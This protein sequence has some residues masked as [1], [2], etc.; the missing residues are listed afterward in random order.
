LASVQPFVPRQGE[1][2]LGESWQAATRLSVSIDADGEV[3]LAR[4]APAFT[5][6]EVPQPVGGLLE[7]E[8]KAASGRGAPH[9][10][11]IADEVRGIEILLTI[12]ALPR[13][14]SLR[15]DFMAG[16]E[17]LVGDDLRL[18][19]WDEARQSCQLS[20]PGSQ[21]LSRNFTLPRGSWLVVV[22]RRTAARTET[23][24]VPLQ[25]EAGNGQ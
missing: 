9:T 18:E 21:F 24:E 6:H 11:T 22:V 12:A 5:A 25:V 3:A 1:Q 19:V 16:D 8:P 2:V 10:W 15:V 7:L 14:F 13:E 4:P 17:P 23:W 20:G